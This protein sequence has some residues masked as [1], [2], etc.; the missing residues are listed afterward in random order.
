M[1]EE[2]FYLSPSG[3][4]IFYDFRDNLIIDPDDAIFASMRAKK[5]EQLKSDNS[6]D[7]ITW[8]VFHSLRQ[9]DPKLWLPSLV[10]VALPGQTPQLDAAITISLWQ[11]VSPPPALIRLGKEKVSEVDVIIESRFW[12]WFIEAKYHSD[13]SPNTTIRP[14]RNQVLRNIDVGSYYAGSR[15]YYFSLLVRSERH[16][17]RGVEKVKQYADLAIPREL[18]AEHRPEGLANLKAVTLMTWKDLG[19]VLSHTG[20]MVSRGD[21]RG[22][23]ERAR[24]WLAGKGLI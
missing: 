22:Y 20:R 18:L 4:K 15:E 10:A 7:A 12:V 24:A 8:N 21:E 23:A 1:S 16:S 3:V 9:I 6:E 19:A 14:T 2:K 13:I 5:L 11:S 17:P